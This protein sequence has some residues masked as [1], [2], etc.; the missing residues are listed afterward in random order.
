MY[1]LYA[2]VFYPRVS[3]ILVE[4]LSRGMNALGFFPLYLLNNIIMLVYILSTW[5]LGNAPISIKNVKLN[6]DAAFFEVNGSDL[7]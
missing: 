4:V 3:G 2:S 1:F 5:S 6:F 7:L